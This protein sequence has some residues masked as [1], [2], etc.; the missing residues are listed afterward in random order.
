MVHIHI[1]NSRK[2]SGY[3]DSAS[4]DELS[5]Q[6]SLDSSVSNRKIGLADYDGAA[7]SPG[8][9][10]SCRRENVPGTIST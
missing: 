8:L 2:Y 9:E 1:A 7:N 5:G 4:S 10:S 3:R 6:A